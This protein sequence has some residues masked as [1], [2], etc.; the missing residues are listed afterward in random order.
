MRGKSDA[1][2]ERLIADLCPGPDDIVLPVTWQRSVAAGEP[3][4]VTLEDLNPTNTTGFVKPSGESWR[5]VPRPFAD[6]RISEG[7]RVLRRLLAT[8]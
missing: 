2:I 4:P 7:R 3:A 8:V 5:R 6:S 1:E